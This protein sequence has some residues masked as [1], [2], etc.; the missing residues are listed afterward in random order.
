MVSSIQSAR[1]VS[2]QILL[3]VLKENDQQSM[4]QASSA[5]ASLL[6]RYGSQSSSTSMTQQ[7]LSALLDSL[8]SKPVSSLPEGNPEPEM[9]KDIT[10]VSYMEGLKKKLEEMAEEPGS[11]ARGKEMLAALKAGTLTVSDPINGISIKA[12]DVDNK[13][14]KTDPT[15]LGVKIE[16]EGWTSYLKSNLAR[17]AD[18]AF[19]RT[20]EGYHV[21]KGTGNSAYFGTVGTEYA[22]FTWSKPKAA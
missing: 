5:R 21:D 7:R 20:P 10:T 4:S 13:E 9:S 15:K 17:G 12:W 19:V 11:A 1:M 14:I 18:A 16:T 6:Q 22:Y 3:K 8:A 2:S